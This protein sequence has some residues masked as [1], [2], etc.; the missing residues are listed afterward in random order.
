MVSTESLQIEDT[1]VK[2]IPSCSTSNALPVVGM[3]FNYCRLS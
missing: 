2:V 1:E 3:N